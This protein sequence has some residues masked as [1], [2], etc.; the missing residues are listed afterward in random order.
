MLLSLARY[1]LL[2]LAFS[3][4]VAMIW[5]LIRRRKSVF[6]YIRG[7]KLLCLMLSPVAAVALVVIYSLWAICV[8]VFGNI[9][10]SMLERVIPHD[11]PAWVGSG[12]DEIFYLKEGVEVLAG[13]DPGMHQ[14][15][16]KIKDFLIRIADPD[17]NA[18]FQ[19]IVAGE[20]LIREK[21]DTP[22][23][24]MAYIAGYEDK[25]PTTHRVQY[26]GWQGNT[27]YNCEV[28]I[29]IDGYYYLTVWYKWR[30]SENA[31]KKS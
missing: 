3:P 18:R 7:H 12:L 30:P 13:G 29:G 19:R 2:I 25:F 5:W 9:A 31:E 1:V 15:N 22:L 28:Y 26:S 23:T 27:E 8:F 4:W 21:W 11:P 20:S 24:G 16:E 10:N 14:Y 6:S 17:N